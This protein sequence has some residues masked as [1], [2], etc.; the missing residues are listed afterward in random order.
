MLAIA[1]FYG[2][3]GQL[4]AV[5]KL[6]RGVA[7]VVV[8]IVAQALWKFAKTALKSAF[9][10]LIAVSALVLHFLNVGEV[11]LIFGAALIGLT[12]RMA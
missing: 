8:A 2:E 3:F 6:L 12:F 4:P 11:K 10:I 1:W 5:E 7:P 9:A